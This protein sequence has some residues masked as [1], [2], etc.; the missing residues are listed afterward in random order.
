MQKNSATCYLK[1]NYLY[2][3]DLSAAFYGYNKEVKDLTD[4]KDK[5]MRLALLDIVLK[6]IGKNPVEHQTNECNS[7]YAEMIE[8][9]NGPIKKLEKLSSTLTNTIS[10]VKK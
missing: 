6:N 3:Y 8:K 5:V 10:N 4:G 7:P 2:K 1:D 9:L